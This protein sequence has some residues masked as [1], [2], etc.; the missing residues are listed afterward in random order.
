MF[1]FVFERGAR[2]AAT[3]CFGYPFLQKVCCSA[4]Y[5]VSKQ[6]NM[7]EGWFELM[8]VRTSVFSKMLPGGLSQ[9]ACLA[10]QAFWDPASHETRRAG[11]L[12]P[13]KGHDPLHVFLD[14]GG[15]LGDEAALHY[16]FACKGAGGLKPC[17]QCSNIFN[18]H[19]AETR[20]C[21]EH[22]V[23]G[24]AQYHTCAD[25]GKVRFQTRDVL[26]A[27]FKRLADARPVMTNTNFE[28]LQTRLGWNFCPQGLLQHPLWG[29]L[30]CP[31]QH[32]LYDAMHVFF[33]G[34]IFNTHVG[35]LLKV[36]QDFGMGQKVLN[37]FVAKFT[38]PK[39]VGS[40][41]GDILMQGGM[42]TI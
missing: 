31:L 38:L 12:L 6:A 13:L 32:G 42:Q 4:M 17:F 25:L 18:K 23:S 16:L 3:H 2:G 30:V 5:A 27:V 36:I 39:I 1:T 8:A 7:K 26:K 19:A 21:V 24:I 20:R 37:E 41:T 28:E 15:F 35:L 11:I 22:D 40:W 9:L 10:V 33:V 34:G 14:L 29:E